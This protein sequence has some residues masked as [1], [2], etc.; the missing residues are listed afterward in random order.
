MEAEAVVES[1]LKSTPTNLI[2]ADLGKLYLE[3][4]DIERAGAFLKEG[5]TPTPETAPIFNNYAISLRRRGL[6]EESMAIY[7]KCIELVS[8]SFAL[9]FN[10]GMVS[11]K[12]RKYDQAIEL[13]EHALR[14]NPSYEPAK[15]Y[16]EALRCRI[17]S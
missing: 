4:G 15:I 2:L 10:A 13:F 11:E 1:L 14:L 5:V 6:F 17:A 7:K 16:L 12:M 3:K 9:Y 8:D